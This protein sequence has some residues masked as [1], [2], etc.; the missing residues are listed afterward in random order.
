VVI[1]IDEYDKPI[2]DYIDDQEIAL[3]NRDVLKQFY[4]VIKASDEF[5]RFAF[6][7]GV[8]KFSTVSV[9]S[10][11]NNLDDITL[12]K[13]YAGMLG[14]TQE[15]LLRYFGERIDRLAQQESKEEWLKN[16]KN[17]YNG[18]SWDGKTFVYNPHS[19]LNLFKKERFDNYWFA[20]ATPT[21]LI[22]KIKTYQTPVERLENYEADGSIFE[23]YDVDRMNVISLLFQ[24]GYLTIKRIE[25][26]SL[27][28]RMYYFSYPNIEVKESFLKHLVSV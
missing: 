7:T 2:I 27:T 19:I 5:N 16:I 26:I 14:Y 9:F 28:Q 25:E 12:D 17:W 24:T 3:G 1:L 20:S 21:F 13:K 15:E 8:S 10:D 11:L 22:K 23:S 6:V 4:G 18:Y